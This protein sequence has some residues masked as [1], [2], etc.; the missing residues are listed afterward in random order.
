MQD[1]TDMQDMT[2]WRG[3][4]TGQVQEWKQE[5]NQRGA[6][7]RR[8]RSAKLASNNTPMQTDEKQDTLLK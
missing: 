6:E 1:M 2:A 5:G 3:G 4:G 7:G 8:Q